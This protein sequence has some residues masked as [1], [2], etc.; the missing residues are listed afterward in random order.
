[1]YVHV[2]TGDIHI[3]YDLPWTTSDVEPM[4]A[5]G[6]NCLI[7][8]RSRISLQELKSVLKPRGMSKP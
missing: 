2:G 7:M 6:G 8:H 4:G 5:E 1:M 3:V